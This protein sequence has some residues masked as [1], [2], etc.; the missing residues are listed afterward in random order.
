MQWSCQGVWWRT[1][2]EGSVTQ[3]GAL[4]AQALA[5]SVQ[6]LRGWAEETEELGLEKRSQVLLNLWVSPL[7]LASTAYLETGGG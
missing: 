4:S 2:L 1:S 6:S 7:P 5:E 3:T